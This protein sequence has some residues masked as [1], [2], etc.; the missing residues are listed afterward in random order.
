MNCT[1]CKKDLI[2]PNIFEIHNKKMCSVPC[3]KK[4]REMLEKSEKKIRTFHHMADHT[5]KH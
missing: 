5:K 4:Y 1:I 2:W 3:C